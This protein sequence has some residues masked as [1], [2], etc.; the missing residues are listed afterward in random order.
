MEKYREWLTERYYSQKCIK[1]FIMRIGLFTKWLKFQGLTLKTIDYKGLLSYIGD[2]QT[3]EKSKTSINTT[4]RSIE[5]YYTFLQ[6]RNIALNV[7][8]RGTYQEQILLLSEEE[9]LQIYSN[10]QNTTKHGYFKYSNKLILGLM[11]FQALDKQDIMNLALKDID[12]TKGTFQ[13]PAGVRRK[14]RE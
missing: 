10:Y 13:V 4:L 1:D 6:I 5:H 11:I 8:L 14:I 9:L 3:Q 7:R 12:L 2:L